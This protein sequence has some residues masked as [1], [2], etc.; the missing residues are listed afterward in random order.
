ML[1]ALDKPENWP[2]NGRE[3]ALQTIMNAVA[4]FDRD[5]NYHTKDSLV[6]LLN[7]YDLNQTSNLGMHRVTS[8]EVCLINCL[9][10]WGHQ[11]PFPSLRC[12]LYNL[13][14]QAVQLQKMAAYI[15]QIQGRNESIAIPEYE[16]G[17]DLP[18]K[19]YYCVYQ[20]FIMKK[21]PFADQII[22]TIRFEIKGMLQSDLSD[23]AKQN[24]L[25]EISKSYTIILNDLSHFHGNKNE[26]IW[27]FTREEMLK[28]FTFEAE[29]LQRS[30]QNANE[31]P[32]RSVLII[33]IG[34]FVLKSRHNYNDDYICKYVPAEVAESSFS[35][36]EIWMRRIADLNDK[37]EGNVVRDLFTN[38]DWIE[39]DWVGEPD[40]SPKRKY[41]ISSFSKSYNNEFMEEYGDV[42]FGYKGDKIAELISPLF[43]R[44]NYPRVFSKNDTNEESYLSQ[45]I[46]F[47]VLY[48]IN[49]V[50]DELNFLFKIINVFCSDVAEKN[51]FLNEILQY[52]IYTVKEPKWATERER[53][54]VLFLYNSYDY[55]ETKMEDGFYKIKTSLFLYPDFL[56]GPHN[57]KDEIAALLKRK[58]A[59]FSRKPYLYCHDCLNSDYDI[60]GLKSS[61]CK[62]PICGG[63]H[64]E[65]VI[66][67]SRS[68]ND[69]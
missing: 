36:H 41:F 2:A 16:K 32:L 29:L 67:D 44:A 63:D 59:F 37:H 8:Y 69:L 60:V 14:G 30:N 24:A 40:F 18:L 21:R 31:R 56:L 43:P 51:E 15:R 39:V 12:F 34:N 55:P 22:D 28:L 20:D 52:W 68:D 1:T 6:S 35:N 65:I 38:H 26:G 46:C 4:A 25:F 45:V 13:V 19:L 57:K 27:R 47:D 7:F 49:E 3:A 33:Q 17:L 66:P 42:V 58:R 5:P 9:F 53:R 61:A 64:T 62:C 54:Y 23:H 48:D 50:K 11:R 10:A